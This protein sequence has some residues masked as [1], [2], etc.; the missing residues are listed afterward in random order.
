MY[1]VGVWP[2]PWT[3]SRSPLGPVLPL[4]Y[5]VSG[6][7]FSPFENLAT[8]SWGCESGVLGGRLALL[9]TCSAFKF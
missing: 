3:S 7:G 5:G 4:E 9:S 2:W 1:T 6:P 8:L